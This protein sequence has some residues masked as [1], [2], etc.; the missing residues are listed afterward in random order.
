LETVPQL[1]PAGHV[2][3]VG[4]HPQTLAV[5]PPAHVWGKVHPEPQLTVPPHPLETVPQLSPAGHVV[6]GVHPHTLAV[7]PPPQVC[8]DVH[9]EPQ[10]TVPPQPSVI[11][12]QLSPAGHAVMQP[13]S[14][15]LESAPLVPEPPAT[16]TCPEPTNDAT[17]KPRAVIIEPVAANVPAVGL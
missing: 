2:V 11:V 17:C 6:I 15:A 16:S 3:T 8:G 4:V 7:P 14:S 10:V 12:P 1:S 5:P 9:P 13:K